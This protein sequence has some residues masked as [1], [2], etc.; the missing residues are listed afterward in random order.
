L[1]DAPAAD[2]A[3][4][5]KFG[6]LVGGVLVALGAW[7]L[8]LYTGALPAGAGLHDRAVWMLGVGGALAALGLAAPGLLRLPHRA[9]MAIGAVLGAVNTHVLLFLTFFLLFVPI[10]SLRRL[11]GARNSRKPPA[12]K[13]FWIESKP[14]ERGKRHFESMF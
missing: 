9:W 8:R 2:R 1:T 7:R 13:T 10:G 5:R 6:L 3:S 12:G 14:D 11:L 4:L